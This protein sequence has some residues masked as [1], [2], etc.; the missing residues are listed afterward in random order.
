MF[1]KHIWGMIKMGNEI[2]FLDGLS[3]C[4]QRA[5]RAIRKDGRTDLSFPFYNYSFRAGQRD[6]KYDVI[7]SHSLSIKFG[8]ESLEVRLYGT[9]EKPALIFEQ[10]WEKLVSKGLASVEW[11]T[12]IPGSA[13]EG[14]PIVPEGVIQAPVLEILSE[15]N[16]RKIQLVFSESMH[17]FTDNEIRPVDIDVAGGLYPT[18]RGLISFKL[19]KES[20]NLLT[21]LFDIPAGLSFCRTGSGTGQS[22]R[23][24]FK[25]E[26]LLAGFD[27]MTV[28][29][30]L[31]VGYVLSYDFLWLN[32][33]TK[34]YQRAERVDLKGEKHSYRGSFGF[35]K[36][37]AIPDIM[38][39]KVVKDSVLDEFL[40]KPSCT[41]NGLACERDIPIIYQKIVDRYYDILR[42]QGS[43]LRMVVDKIRELEQSGGIPFMNYNAHLPQKEIAKGS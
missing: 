38:D 3:K 40:S 16:G 34:S 4:V 17:G 21:E 12:T 22:G 26:E 33:L 41:G 10:A 20:P 35:G 42:E 8:G 5:E 31:F 2:I 24:E 43:S 1:V 18:E 29:E 23:Y 37:P 19:L 32:D 25:P 9:A 7:L 27:F 14:K 11:D 36:R 13:V 39:G 30:G 6:K 15:Y 28:S